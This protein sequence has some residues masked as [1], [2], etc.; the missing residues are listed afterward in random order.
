MAL[1]MKH[2]KP[3]YPAYVTLFGANAVV[4]DAN[5]VTYL[6]KQRV[7]AYSW[8]TPQVGLP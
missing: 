8:I 2:G 7:L 4:L 6:F 3:A 1:A 5:A